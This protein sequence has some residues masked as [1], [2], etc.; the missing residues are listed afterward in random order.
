MC[1]IKLYARYG[2][3]AL[4]FKLITPCRCGPCLMMAKVLEEVS[5]YPERLTL[6]RYLMSLDMV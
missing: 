6:G 1:C 3:T 2:C 4:H 5:A